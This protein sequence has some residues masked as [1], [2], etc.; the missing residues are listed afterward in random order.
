[1]YHF[2]TLFQIALTTAKVPSPSNRFGTHPVDPKQEYNTVLPWKRN[3]FP[4]EHCF[5]GESWTRSAQGGLK[6]N[7]LDQ[8]RTNINELL[9]YIASTEVVEIL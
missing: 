6:T 1:M 8:L 7:D 2:P 5:L 3:Q 4:I 9:S